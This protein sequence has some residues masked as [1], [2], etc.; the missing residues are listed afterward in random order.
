[1]SVRS[2]GDFH[3]WIEQQTAIHVKAVSP[4]GDPI[5]L[6]AKEARAAAELLEQ[7]A[8]ELEQLDEA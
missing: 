5:E 6:S 8:E 4:Y 2:I 7:L 3:A 1:M